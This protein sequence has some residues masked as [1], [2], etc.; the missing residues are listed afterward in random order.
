MS[1]RQ[2]GLGAAL[3]A[4]ALGG[5]FGAASAST[6]V[7][8]PTCSSV[9]VAL[10]RQSLG[11]SP[12]KPTTQTSANVLICHY[13]TVDLVYLLNQTKAEFA[14]DE[15]SNGGKSLSGIGSAAFTYSAKGSAVTSLEVLDGNVAFLISGSTDSVKRLEQLAKKMVPII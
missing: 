7:H 10:V 2:V 15:K 12:R 13:A 9:S 8:T 5:S 3:T 14:S 4:V 11:G 1:I 6:K